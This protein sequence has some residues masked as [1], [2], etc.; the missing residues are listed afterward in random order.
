MGRVYKRDSRIQCA[1]IATNV[2]PWG[3]CNDC[4]LIHVP[5]CGVVVDVLVQAA[6][7]SAWRERDAQHI[8]IA[9]QAG[10]GKTLAYLIPIF[11]VWC[12]TQGFL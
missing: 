10:S 5:C 12:E 9:D 11:Q 2:G 7:L 1:C 6:T 3:A 8:A 4:V